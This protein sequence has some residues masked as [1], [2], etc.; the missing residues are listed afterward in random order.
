MVDRFFFAL[1]LVSMAG[2]GPYARGEAI[3]S[4]DSIRNAAARFVLS[5]LPPDQPGRPGVEVGRL[6]P[7]LRLVACDQELEAFLPPGGRI[8]GG[9]TVGVRCP[10]SK[11]WSL[12]V[13]VKVAMHARI[14][15]AARP[16]ARGTRLTPEDLQLEERDVAALTQGYLTAPQQA[17]GQVLKRSIP[18]GSPVVP[19]ALEAPHAIRRG[20]KVT[21]VARGAGGVEV[22]M[23]GTALMDGAAGERI[24]VRNLSSERTVEGTVAGAGVVEVNL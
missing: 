13:P 24:R 1:L 18:G 20:E 7:R 9:T 3:Q 2:F 19:A 17:Y 23:A 22:R 21:V 16:L 14:L 8:I 10:G 5:Q 6:D 12:Y 11:P 15:V 4:E